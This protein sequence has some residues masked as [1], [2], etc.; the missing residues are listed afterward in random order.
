MVV[1][2]LQKVDGGGDGGGGDGGGDGGGGDGG[3]DGGGGDGG[4]GD[5]DATC[6]YA[7]ISEMCNV[8]DGP[9]RTSVT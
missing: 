6:E 1:K 5:G 2:V 3:G 8:R 9:G 4:G 7:F